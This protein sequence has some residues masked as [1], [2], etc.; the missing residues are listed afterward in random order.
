MGGQSTHLMT[1]PGSTSQTLMT[2]SRS[3]PPTPSMIVGRS[4]IHLWQ[5]IKELLNDPNIYSGFIHWT[6]REKG[7][8]KIVDSQRVAKL[9]GKRKNRPAMNFDKLSRSLR[10][11][12][13]KG[14][15][16]KTDRPQR[17]VYQFC[18]PYHH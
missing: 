2:S 3:T 17:L 7:I 5:F 1:S 18:A 10:Q 11:Y 9:W 14:I 8:F 6:D 16:K 12:Y 15:M 4:N 13:R